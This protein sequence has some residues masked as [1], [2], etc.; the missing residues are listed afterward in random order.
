MKPFCTG[1]LAK[2]TMIFGSVAISGSLL[3]PTSL[4]DGPIRCWGSDDHGQCAAPSILGSISAIAAGDRHSVAVNSF[5]QV[6]AWGSSAHGQSALPAGRCTGIAAGRLHTVAIIDGWVVCAGN[7]DF[8][9]CSVQPFSTAASVAAGDL[10]SIV[11]EYGGQLRCWGYSAAF[12]GVGSD[13]LGGFTHADGGSS[14]T[15]ARRS[16]G[17]VFAWGLTAPAVLA[18]PRGVDDAVAV[19]A[20]SH[21]S[22]GLRADGTV[23]C[24]GIDD[25]GQCSPPEWLS[26][27]TQ[28]AAAGR[29]SLALRANGTVTAWG[30]GGNG[31]FP[32]GWKASGLCL[33]AA[34]ESH[35]L[36]VQP[37]AMPTGSQ[38]AWVHPGGGTFRTI[39]AAIDGTS[40]TSA[41]TIIVAPGTYTSAS[42]AVAIIGDRDITLVAQDPANP[43]I[44][45]GQGE[46]RGVMV[47]RG[48]RSSLRMSGFRFVNCAGFAITEP[49]P[50][51]ARGGAILCVSTDHADIED[52]RFED[53]TAE[54]GGAVSIDS[55]LYGVPGAPG[56]ASTTVLRRCEFLRCR[57]SCELVSWHPLV[58]DCTFDSCYGGW[59]GAL[60]SSGATVRRCHFTQNG[61]PQPTPGNSTDFGGALSLWYGFE[62]SLVEDCTF[63]GN[64]ALRGGAMSVLSAW[65]SPPPQRNIVRRCTFTNNE[66]TSPTL[67]GG[68]AIFGCEWL[69][70]VECDF[71]GNVGIPA[72]CLSVSPWRTASVTGCTFDTC[73]PLFPTGIAAVAP[74][75]KAPERCDD[76][77]GDID[78]NGVVNGADLGLLVASWGPAPTGLASDTNA[79]GIVDGADLGL[80]LVGWGTCPQ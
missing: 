7:N 14:H 70:V 29:Y 74:D 51:H 8:G 73:C 23:V 61:R 19:A 56:Q 26:N 42:Q 49:I 60:T 47:V 75:T 6:F 34:G 57:Q 80:L 16:D 65:N 12:H 77:L 46:R 5:G 33:I 55:G 38:T 22:I 36:A 44:I 78:C 71:S 66:A 24:W 31:Q 3:A 1:P 9:Q 13:E 68:G 2:R 72:R 37:P 28:V 27:V 43:P 10:H 4:A 64:S 40:S 52:C 15:I 63:T 76:C 20:G 39:Q 58:E 62:P 53:C 11:I 17:R 41:T 35:T 69:D 59:G 79:D 21:H 50:V 30:D 45:D 32:P 48:Y 54:F 67:G 25:R 18:I